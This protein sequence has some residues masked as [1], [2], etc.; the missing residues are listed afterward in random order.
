[1]YGIPHCDKVKKARL[2]LQDQGL[3]YHFH[4][5]KKDGVPPDALAR[6][7]QA[8]GWEVLLNRKGT[9]WR[10]L[11]AAL[12]ASVTDAASAAAL[13]QAQASVIKRPVVQWPDGRI[14]VGF[15]PERFASLLP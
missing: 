15:T 14:S 3:A 12:Q 4:D 6:W 8:V 5:F 9:T 1:M 11:D 13:M 7:M 10:K 2:W